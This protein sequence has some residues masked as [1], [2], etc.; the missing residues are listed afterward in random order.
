MRESDVRRRLTRAG[1]AV[2][3][4]VLSRA[5]G[6]DRP[7]APEAD[8]EA[9]QRDP[10]CGSK[11]AMDALGEFFRAQG[12]ILVATGRTAGRVAEAAGKAAPAS[13]EAASA[14]KELGAIAGDVAKAGPE[15][16]RHAAALD[17]ALAELESD[18]GAAAALDRAAVAAEGGALETSVGPFTASCAGCAAAMS[19]AIAELGGAA[20]GG[21]GPGALASGPCGP[22]LEDAAR[23]GELFT[24]IR[25][26]VG[27]VVTLAEAIRRSVQ[28]LAAAAESL[29][30][31]AQ[32]LGAG[33]QEGLERI[34]AALNRAID[35]ITGAGRT[36]DSEVAPRAVKL[37]PSLLQQLADNTDRLVACQGKLQ[38]LAG[39]RSKRLA[40]IR[41]NGT[42]AVPGDLT[43]TR[44]VAKIHLGA[45]PPTRGR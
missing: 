9:F 22:A 18:A 35:A 6:A 23:I 29:A 14:R 12:E 27:A 5:A 45:L 36:Y 2:L 13:A 39:R 19:A 26:F 7:V 30:R 42:L 10:Q 11:A 17:K 41:F 8:L 33:S 44:P 38:D 24:K 28:D 21:A 25:R 4:A 15:A 43:L 34:G 31:L 3:F 32:E 40:P 16:A 1:L 20:A 37:K